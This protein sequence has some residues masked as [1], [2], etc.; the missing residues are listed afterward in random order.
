MKSEVEK[1]LEAEKEAGCL[2]DNARKSSREKVK[3]A[4]DAGEA[5][6]RKAKE[7]ARV[8]AEDLLHVASEEAEL[9]ARRIREEANVR[10]EATVCI[11][12]N[13]ELTFLAKHIDRISGITT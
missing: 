10:A 11:A 12:A 13:L 4:R 6:I 7:R 9:E 8:A 1:V 3:N 5:T 2:L